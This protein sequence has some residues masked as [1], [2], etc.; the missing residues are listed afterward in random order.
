MLPFS[1]AP[2][3]KHGI[4]GEL[5]ELENWKIEQQSLSFLVSIS[6]FFYVLLYVLI[7]QKIRIRDHFVIT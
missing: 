2:S 6:I 3:V 5:C 4:L 7:V 1:R